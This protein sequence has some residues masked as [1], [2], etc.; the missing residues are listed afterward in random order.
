LLFL[1]LP[2]QVFD[3][4]FLTVYSIVQDGVVRNPGFGSFPIDRM[5]ANGITAVLPTPSPTW[6]PLYKKA[7]A[8]RRASKHACNCTCNGPSAAGL[9]TRTSDA[10]GCEACE[11][12]HDTDG[13]REAASETVR[14][15]TST[16]TPSDAPTGDRQNPSHIAYTTGTT[17]PC[18]IL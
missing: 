4:A 18:I 8:T 12:G 14:R 7:L 9:L 16:S 11:E 3:A 6:T 1:F 5:P 10:V 13:P 2:L 17:M 15:M